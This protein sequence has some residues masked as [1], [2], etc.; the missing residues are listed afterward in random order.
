MKNLR[1]FLFFGLLV[2]FAAALGLATRQ[3]APESTLP[4]VDNPGPLGLRAIYLYLEEGG[5]TVEAHR[6]SLEALPPSARTVVIAAPAGRSVSSDEVDKV[7][8][9]LLRFCKGWKEWEEESKWQ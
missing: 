6:D 5:A 7:R 2:T 3:A 8:S 4:S 9:D 1:T